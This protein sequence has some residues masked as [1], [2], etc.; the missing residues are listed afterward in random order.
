MSYYT[1]S[2][3]L[4]ASIVNAKAVA[5][6]TNTR[7]FS[8]LETMTDDSTYDLVASKAFTGTG[9]FAVDTSSM[10]TP[11]GTKSFATVSG[12]AVSVDSGS[13]E[14]VQPATLDP[15]TGAPSF[16]A[17]TTLGPGLYYLSTAPAAVSYTSRNIEFNATG[18]NFTVAVFGVEG[19]R[20][21]ETDAQAYIDELDA[22]AATPL[23]D[24]VRAAISDLVVGLK[25]DGLWASI[26]NCYLLCGPK[27]M[28]GARLSLKAP[29]VSGDAL[30]DTTANLFSDLNLDRVNGVAV[31]PGWTQA[32]ATIQPAS[33]VLTT[34]D[35]HVA[36]YVSDAGTQGFYPWSSSGMDSAYL[37]CSWDGTTSA[38]FKFGGSTTPSVTAL[39]SAQLLGAARQSASSLEMITASGTTN[40]LADA[41]TSFPLLP[42]ELVGARGGQGSP[43]HSN[44]R[45]AFASYGGY[46]DLSALRS[47]VNAY[48]A[49]ISASGI[50]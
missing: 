41:A 36:T 19:P 44:A 14:F 49:A 29:T 31:R 22:L 18:A 47:R 6:D 2:N 16:A 40:V 23:E 30:N 3:K 13:V 11:Y 1:V 15:L 12:I 4:T 34:S 39:G 38:S 8:V 21:L 20:I 33:Q 27:T 35:A 7:S 32:L 17:S 9:S 28:S 43:T 42:I 5:A 24:S 45:I 26:E 37:M 10:E 46:L 48:V 50:S 25:A